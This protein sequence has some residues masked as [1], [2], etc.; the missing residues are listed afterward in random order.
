[1]NPYEDP[2]H[3]AQLEDTWPCIAALF[4]LGIIVTLDDAC[5]WLKNKLTTDH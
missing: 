4:V 3:E 1:M 5:R 2:E